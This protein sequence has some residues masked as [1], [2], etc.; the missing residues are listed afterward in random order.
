VR[1]AS[2]PRLV[3]DR[4]RGRLRAAREW[5][6]VEELELGS[7]DPGATEL[8]AR[9]L[10]AL[11]AVWN[12]HL[13]QIDG[14]A[15]RGI[16]VPWTALGLEGLLMDRGWEA[17]IGAIARVAPALEILDATLL[18]PRDRLFAAAPDLVRRLRC[19]RVRHLP[20]DDVDALLGRSVPTLEIVSFPSAAIVSRHRVSQDWVITVAGGVMS[21]AARAIKNAASVLWHATPG[22]IRRVEVRGALPAGPTRRTFHAAVERQGAQLGTT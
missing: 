7:H 1:V 14:L 5:R 13:V 10:P 16:Q 12:L 9:P 2:P 18:H 11:R 3:R 8:L 15:E 21:L 6:T 4:D 19:L 17:S 20:N 22:T